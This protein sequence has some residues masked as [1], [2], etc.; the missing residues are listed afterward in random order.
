MRH[1]TDFDGNNDNLGSHWVIIVGRWDLGRFLPL[2][3]QILC[4]KDGFRMQQCYDF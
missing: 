3:G 2:G 4:H 1:G